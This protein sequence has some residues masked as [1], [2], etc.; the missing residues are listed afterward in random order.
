MAFKFETGILGT[1]QQRDHIF[2]RN[3]LHASVLLSSFL[4][5]YG[6]AQLAALGNGDHHVRDIR[7]STAI[8]STGRKNVM[9]KVDGAI[10]DSSGN[11]G[12]GTI[13]YLL[14]VEVD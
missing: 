7:A 4:L 6:R 5:G 11:S 12:G 9:V 10:D 2:E 8:I 1:G 13:G 3:V 14:I